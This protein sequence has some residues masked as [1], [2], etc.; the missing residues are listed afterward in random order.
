MTLNISN[1]KPPLQ[2]AENEFYLTLRHHS[3]CHKNIFMF[4]TAFFA[5]ALRGTVVKF[6]K[7][8]GIE[9]N[10]FNSFITEKEIILPE[11]NGVELMDYSCFIKG[12]LTV[13]CYNT[14]T[15]WKL[16]NGYA[17]GVDNEIK[18]FHDPSSGYVSPYTKC[19]G[20]GT[21]RYIARNLIGYLD[22]YEQSFIRHNN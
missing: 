21:R 12:K 20:D 14:L 2:V 8:E 19:N 10:A 13:Y 6:N 16:L 4:D 7:I 3:Y 1:N 22:N 17:G 9:G 11:K 18:R 15:N 5:E